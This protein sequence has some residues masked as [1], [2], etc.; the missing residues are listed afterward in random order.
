M[1]ALE[2]LIQHAADCRRAVVQARAVKLQSSG[3]AYDPALVQFLIDGNPDHGVYAPMSC[4]LEDGLYL[5]SVCVN[6]H[7]RS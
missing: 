1:F 5:G 6:R 2:V 3:Q 7:F 4:I